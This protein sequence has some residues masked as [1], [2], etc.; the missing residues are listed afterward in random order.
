M[1]VLSFND[2]VLSSGVTGIGGRKCMDKECG[3]KKKPLPAGNTF[4]VFSMMAGMIGVFV[5]KDRRKAP[6]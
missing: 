6:L 2:S 5:S 3:E 4:R 1:C